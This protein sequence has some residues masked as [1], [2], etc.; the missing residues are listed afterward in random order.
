MAVNNN[1]YPGV[2][3]TYMPAFLV[4]DKICKVYFSLSDY[5]S[6]TDI[7]NVQV[8]VAHQK[9]NN[10]ALSSTKY[11]SQIML[12][13]LKKDTNRPGDDKYYIEIKNTDLEGGNFY[14][15]QFYKVQIRFTG[16]GAAAQSLTTPQAIDT[17]LIANQ[18]YFSEWSSVCLI[19]GISK[20]SLSILGFGDPD[21]EVTW[22]A[23]N[24]QLIGKLDFAD[25]NETETLKS[26][27]IRLYDN[28]TDNLLADSGIQ[29]SDISN[30]VNQFIYTFKYFL[31]HGSR[32]Y[33]TIDYTTQNLYSS[34][35]TYH[36]I[37]SRNSSLVFN[38]SSFETGL[39]IE[40]G[41]IAVSIKSEQNFNDDLAILRSSS[42]TD[43]TVWE[44]IHIETINTLDPLNYTWFDYTI[45]S[46]MLYKY[47]VQRR[48]PADNTQSML[49]R[50]QD[51]T[52]IILE[53]M[54]LS[55]GNQQ[56][57]IEFNPNIS[58]MKRMI[59][60]SKTETLGSQFPYIKRNGAMN[61]RTFPISGLISFL[62]DKDNLFTSKADIYGENNINLYDA[63]E[64]TFNVS[65]YNNYTYEREFRKKVSQFLSEDNLKLFRSA[66]EGNILVRLTDV[67]FSPE[68][69]TGR[70]IWTFS[71]TAYEIDDCSI[72][73]FDKY[74]IQP[75]KGE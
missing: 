41:R 48:H 12:T 23:S 19:R 66:T 74:G 11:P 45:E 63:F 40:N 4:S 28:D 51:P 72:E 55:R 69:V 10:T 57:K 5:N 3:D 39:D 14:I 54:Y 60:D 44:D 58:S 6:E 15:D 20:P 38:I 30:N 47:A 16:T 42:D 2:I 73:N 37:V 53:H 65:Y 7:K 56:L 75:V 27:R 52:G 46:G 59:S 29:Y 43:F 32:Y 26:Y 31:E 9:M 22:S 49:V 62:S 17:W 70:Y 13:T 61:Y 71:C 68:T 35:E 34:S 67:S 33:F 50:I 64:N 8:T 1:L 24:I 21:I 25:E 36:M 18:Q